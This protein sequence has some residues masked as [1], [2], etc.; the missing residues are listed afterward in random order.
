MVVNTEGGGAPVLT[1][2]FLFFTVVGIGKGTKMLS[3][4]L[5]GSKVRSMKYFLWFSL[6]FVQRTS[7]SKGRGWGSVIKHLFGVHK[8]PG[9]SFSS[10]SS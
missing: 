3:D 1:V 4:M 8:V 10:T 6:I 2:T 5:A 9:V 7:E